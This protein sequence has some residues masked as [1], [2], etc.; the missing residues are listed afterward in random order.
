MIGTKKED[1]RGGRGRGRGEKEGERISK[2]RRER[3]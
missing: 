3:G 2:R 1:G